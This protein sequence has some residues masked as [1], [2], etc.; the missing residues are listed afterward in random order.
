MTRWLS[1]AAIA[2][3]IAAPLAWLAGV[4]RWHTLTKDAQAHAL[5]LHPAT[6]TASDPHATR[7]HA[8]HLA[9]VHELHRIDTQADQ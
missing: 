2:A 5:G 8:A 7:T 3:S 6:H 4:I 1:V 9:T